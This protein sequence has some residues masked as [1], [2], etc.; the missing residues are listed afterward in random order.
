MPSKNSLFD[1]RDASW[2]GDPKWHTSSPHFAAYAPPLVLILAIL[3]IVE[4]V[5]GVVWITSIQSL[6]SGWGS[7]TFAQVIQPLLVPA[8]SFFNTIPSLHLHVLARSNQP[9]M[10]AIF[11]G[12]LALIF[13]GSAV[14]FLPPC[15]GSNVPLPASAF[16]NASNNVH[17]SGYQRTECPSGNNRGIWGTIIALQFITFVGYTLHMAMALRVKT[18]HKKREIAIA[19]GDL[20]EMVDED[21]KRRREEDARERWR[22]M[23]NL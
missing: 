18:Q 1:F 11:S 7:L 2:K 3:S 9:L 17:I 23:G 20:V 16:D 21:A 22:E 15:V 10:A 5:L 6:G 4:I 13:L 14:A 8:L 12:L 19:S